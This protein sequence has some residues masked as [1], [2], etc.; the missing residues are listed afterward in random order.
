M[1]TPGLTNY[2]GDFVVL[3][4]G[5][6]IKRDLQKNI[7]SDRMAELDSGDEVLVKVPEI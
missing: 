6:W 1:M 3:D 7:E 4:N 2:G 5:L